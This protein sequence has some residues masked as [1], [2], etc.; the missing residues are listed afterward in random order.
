MNLL[1]PI[2]KLCPQNSFARGVSILVGGTAGAQA[3]MILAAP[4]LTRLYTPE[5]FGLLAVYSGLLA[6]FAV[7]ASL[8]YELA[9]P[10]PESNSEA[11]NVLVLSLLVVILMTGIS[12]IMVLVAGEQM[13]DVLN[14]PKLASYFWLLPLGVFLSGIYN[15]FNYWAVRTQAFGDIARTRVSQTLVTLVVQLLGF[16]LGG[17]ALLL[18]QT[19][20]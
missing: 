19:G 4:L 9:I 1:N 16:K 6:I 11:A 2:K 18:G 7:V 12:A 5:Y 15:I 14:T 3:L 13:A 20:G 17:I 8:Q 10:L